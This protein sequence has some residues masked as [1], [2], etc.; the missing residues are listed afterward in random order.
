MEK[1]SEFRKAAIAILNMF[2]VGV[3]HLIEGTDINRPYNA[4]TLTF[5]MHRLFGNFDLFLERV[6]ETPHTYTIKPFDPFFEKG[7]HLPVSRTFFEP[8][9]NDFSH[10]TLRLATC[11]TSQALGNTSIVFLRI[12]RMGWCGR[13]GL[14]G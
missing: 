4:I 5:E 9:P 11:F 7:L 12:G 6:T 3:I 2:D 14:R 13:M 1:K 10:F 8:P